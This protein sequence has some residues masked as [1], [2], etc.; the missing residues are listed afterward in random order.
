MV[1]GRA[2]HRLLI[3]A[4]ALQCLPTKGHASAARTTSWA[5]AVLRPT[6]LARQQEGDLGDRPFRPGGRSGA[7]ADAPAVLT[8]AGYHAGFR[9]L[10]RMIGPA[11]RPAE[12]TDLVVLL[13]VATLAGVRLPALQQSSPASVVQDSLLRRVGKRTAA[14]VTR[15]TSGSPQ[16]IQ[17]VT[18]CADLNAAK[19]FAHSLRD[20][21]VTALW[22]Q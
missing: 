9:T 19:Y 21:F 11:E 16:P 1:I 10:S 8:A 14:P 12:S 17:T 18:T 6:T 20:G 15:A 3:A 13:R 7:V 22:D 2:H 4:A 5:A